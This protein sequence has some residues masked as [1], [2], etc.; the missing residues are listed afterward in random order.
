MPAMLKTKAEADAFLK[1]NPK[2]CI[3]FTATWCGPCQRIAPKF[4]ELAEEYKG[5]VALCKIDVDENSES[6]EA[7]GVECMPTFM[8]FHNGQ[9]VDTLQG[10]SD[11]ELKAKIEKLKAL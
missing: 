4:A 10:A 11:A 3:D 9:K 5:A 2:V 7:F 1:E 6:S 8:F